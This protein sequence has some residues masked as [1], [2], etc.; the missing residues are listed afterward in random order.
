MEGCKPYF[1]ICRHCGREARPRGRG[2]CWGCF[3]DPE[4]RTQY[5]P[6]PRQPYR[7]LSYDDFNGGYQLAGEPTDS[8]PGSDGKIE[9]LAQRFDLKV[10]LWHP[11]DKMHGTNGHPKQLPVEIGELVD[12]DDD[13]GD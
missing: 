3:A 11:L 1:A 13:G 6:L 10:S 2:L 4:L 12:S 5:Q 7:K 8:M 9:V